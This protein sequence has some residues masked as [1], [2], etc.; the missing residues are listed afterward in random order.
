LIKNELLEQLRAALGDISGTDCVI[1]T[2]KEC[3]TSDYVLRTPC[4]IAFFVVVEQAR[5]LAENY[6]KAQAEITQIRSMMGTKWP[7]DLNLV[8]LVGG[9]TYVNS[10]SRREIIDDRYVCRKFMLNVSGEDIRNALNEL[11]FWPPGDLVGGPPTLIHGGVREV[12]K[13]YDS[14]LIADLASHS[15]G[16][17]RIFQKILEGAY[18]FTGEPSAGEEVIA[19]RVLES[20]Q[21]RLEALDITDFRGIKRLRPEDMP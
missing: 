5:S 17:E 14:R 18:S 20:S 8:L 9:D 4:F 2:V 1:Q 7:R 13:G 6:R 12:L 3:P 10:A 11:P 19:P 15:P 16:A 21:T